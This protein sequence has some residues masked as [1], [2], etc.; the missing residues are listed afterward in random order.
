MS[1]NQPNTVTLPPFGRSRPV[2]LIVGL[3]WLAALSP[4]AFGEPTNEQQLQAVRQ[5]IEA[6][7]RELNDTRGQRNAL[8][9]ELRALDQSI[10][11]LAVAARRTERSIEANR[12]RLRTL[13]RQ[14]DSAHRQLGAQAAALEGNIRAA[15]AMGRQDYLKLLLNQEEPARV[16]R[17]LA[18]YRYLGAARSERIAELRATLASVRQLE[19]NIREIDRELS[20]LR[21]DA[22]EKKAAFQA[23]RARRELVLAQ[24]NR[25]IRERAQELERLKAD[26][27]R[28]EGL[29]R[30]LTEYLPELPPPDREARFGRLKGRLAWPTAGTLAARFGEPKQ[31]GALRWRGVLIAAREGTEV[32]SV[33]SGRVAYADWLRGFGLLLIL[34]HGDGY[35]TLYGHNQAL[36]KEVGNWVEAG[37]TIATVGSSGDINQAGLYF[38]IRHQGEPVDPSTW[39]GGHSRAARR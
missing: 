4:A 25:E 32:R 22:A 8:R 34:D 1:A 11:R 21:A 19:E 39:V 12:S 17:M 2:R 3:G 6:V 38:E 26:Q 23:E 29:V 37:E 18:Y 27:Q 20:A 33:A 9:E 31:I 16:A 24:L 7:T 13:K 36:H 15:Y 14:A 28:L 5:R 10:G 30:R 35:M